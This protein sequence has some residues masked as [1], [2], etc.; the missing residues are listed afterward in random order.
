MSLYLVDTNWVID[1]L[2]AEPVAVQT[3]ADLTDDGL[4]ISLI[5]YAELYEG[6]YYARDPQTALAGMRTF[7]RKK[8]ILPLTAAIAERFA[9]VCGELSRHLRRQIGDLDL[10]IAATAI[11]HNLTVLTRNVK[12]FQHI[13]GLSIFSPSR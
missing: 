5:T 8:E 13:P 1:A 10:L 4:A 9:V 6:A 3:L 2:H 12:D 11:E 7:L